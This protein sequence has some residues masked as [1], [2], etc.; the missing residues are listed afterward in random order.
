M[1]RGC[2]LALAAAL[3]ACLAAPQRAA[4]EDAAANPPANQVDPKV[5]AILRAACD[6]LSHAQTLS[7]TAVDTYEHAALN[8]QPLFYTV[9]NKVTMQ[10]PDK[11]RVIKTGD[12]VPDEFYYDGKKMMAYVPSADLVA[13]ADAPPTVEQMLDAAWNAAAI[14]F[15]F[16]D[17]IVDDP[18]GVFDKKMKSAFYVGQ[19]VVVGGTTTDIVAVAGDDV[20]AELWIGAEDH[21]PRM[22]RVNYPN[23]PAHAH[24]QTDYS[25]W[26]VGE[27]VDA[28]AFTSAKAAA[29]KRMAFE[30]PGAKP[31]PSRAEQGAAVTKQP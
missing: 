10:R 16:A 7:F 6:K 4:A 12:G 21:L 22:I 18:C 25:D 20:Q 29:G 24:Y 13:M 23:E 15:P 5:K 26:H 8:G 30:P 28:G 1:R 11:L 2:Q 14:Y 17:L 27:A 3:A 19:S 31:P 9:E